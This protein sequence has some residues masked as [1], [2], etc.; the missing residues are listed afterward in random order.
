MQR[1][2]LRGAPTLV[3]ANGV[4]GMIKRRFPPEFR[5]QIATLVMLVFEIGLLERFGVVTSLCCLELSPV[6]K[7]PVDKSPVAERSLRSDG[8]GRAPATRREI[9]GLEISGTSAGLRGNFL[10]DSW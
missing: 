5:R 7:N 4:F 6:D 1:S 10:D 3:S 8:T 9:G 2:V